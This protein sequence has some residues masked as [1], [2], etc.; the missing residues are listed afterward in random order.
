M[1]FKVRLINALYHYHYYHYHLSWMTVV[2]EVNR[3]GMNRSPIGQLSLPSLRGRQIEYQPLAGVGVKAGHA[4][5]RWVEAWY[6]TL[7]DPIW[8]VMIPKMEFH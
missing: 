7:C 3:L 2:C 6:V 5:L 4:H 8:Q 1:M